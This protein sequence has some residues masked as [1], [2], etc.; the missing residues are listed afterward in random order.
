MSEQV[1][2]KQ[3]AE[4][5]VYKSTIDG[6]LVVA[7]QRFSKTY[8][9]PELD[10]KLTRGR[11]NQE[12][13]SLKRCRE[14]GIRV[15]EVVR[16]DKDSATL[17]MQ[18]IDGPTLKDWILNN[19][20]QDSEKGY[21]LV[22]GKILHTMHS[23]SIIHG[24]LT[25][26][27]MIIDN[28]G[29]VVLIDFGLSQISSSVEDKAVDLYVLERAFISTH[30][31]SAQLFALVLEAYDSSDE[32]KAVLRRL[33][34]V[35]QP[36]LSTETKDELTLEYNHFEAT[37]RQQLETL[38]LPKQ[39]WRSLF[40]KIS[41]NTLDIGEYVVFCEGETDDD[42]GSAEGVS[43]GLSG[44][45]LCLT[46]DRLE[47]F[48][49]VFL[50]DHAW[51][52]TVEKAADELNDIPE[53]MDRMERLTGIY[54]PTENVPAMP[55]TDSLDSAMAVNVPVVVSQAGVNEERAHELLR[56]TGGDIVEAIV[57]A[58]EASS[59]VSDMQ[60]D[61]QTKILEQLS[62]GGGTDS[63]QP[64]EWST[65]KYSCVQYSLDG[66]E[67]LD[68]ID[69]RIPVLPFVTSGDVKCTFSQRHALISVSGNTVIDG[70]LHADIGSDEATWTID[71][72]VLTITLVKKRPEYWPV[73]ITGERHISPAA[74]KK[75]ILRVYN[76][77]WRYFQ[78][79]DYVA[80]SLDQ[81]SFVKR[82]N[83][84]IQ[85]EVGLAI[86][87]S[88]SPNVRSLPLIYLDKQGQMT[89]FNIVWPIQSIV[90]GQLLSRDY[91]PRWLTEP[92]QR[93][94]Y[95]HAIFKG[96]TQCV[97]DA[98]KSLVE[99]W[100][101]VAEK[102]KIAALTRSHVSSAQAKNVYI[103]GAPVEIK[104]A[105][106]SAGLCIVDAE[107]SADIVFD[108]VTEVDGKPT[109]KH[110]L[111][112]VFSSSELT[113]KALQAIVGA[114][115]WLCPGFDMKS[116]ICEFIG[117][118]LMDSNSWWLLSS[119][120]A[121][122]DFQSQAIFTNDWVAAVRHIDVGYTTVVKCAPPAIA[123]NHLY[124]IEKRA[125]LTPDNRLYIWSKTIWAHRHTIRMGEKN[126][127]PYQALP[128]AEAVSND[129]L[130][131][132]LAK[133]FGK[134]AFEKLGRDADEIVAEIIRLMLGEGNSD[135]KNFGLFSFS[136]TLGRHYDTVSPFL[137]RV[138]P[139]SSSNIFD[140]SGGTVTIVPE[141]VAA[142]SGSA[143]PSC[144][145]SME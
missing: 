23:H 94:G 17:Y 120:Q 1:L 50:V 105:V 59:G 25:T 2:I 58:N 95:L 51:T 79:Y 133:Q 16:Q 123:S 139:V 117:A 82:T 137:Y 62:G 106:E 113:V 131:Q 42:N 10:K 28:D 53:L 45:R 9:H 83:W 66:D 118:A 13:R 80:Q 107:D 76:D 132:L 128:A 138:K 111:N 99:G 21:M 14:H 78:G 129:L 31:N 144:W 4:A 89:P 77:L 72:N 96:P 63:E 18:Y 29:E 112:G 85:D 119:D 3:G 19:S 109:S 67:Q 87:H 122:Q 57:L 134:G 7:K 40:R 141:V 11:L 52:T 34:D 115:E 104:K 20:N 65:R 26:S 102:A 32:A 12:A 44:H 73:A 103:C 60:K 74:H 8:R 5:R 114:K 64:L 124:V 140:G 30:P 35:R 84:Y 90:K 48:S 130:T 86:G 108:N 49:D 101:K 68:A 37:H 22:V 145:K 27:N 36:A 54:E 143:N 121:E 110:P 6:K 33:E 126:P 56:Q 136:F 69:I 15:P 61:I 88:D 116:Q 81:Q 75:H 142:L 39:L 91:C 24:D 46:K 43:R 41:N 38:D 92:D 47:E 70:D 98:Y 125:L 97:L 127:E 93:T 55:D 135:G 100:T 71:S